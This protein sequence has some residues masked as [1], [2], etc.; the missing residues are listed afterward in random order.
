MEDRDCVRCG[1]QL[2]NIGFVLV[3][4][5]KTI[6]LAAGCLLRQMR[7]VAECEPPPRVR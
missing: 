3:L 1:V 2:A 4:A 5:L 6:Q 7:A